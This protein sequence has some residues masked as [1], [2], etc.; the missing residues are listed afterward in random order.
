MKFAMRFT[1]LHRAISSLATLC[2]PASKA[3]PL[4]LLT[5][6]LVWMLTSCS[7]RNQPNV[8]LVTIDSLRADHLSCYG[9]E[10]LTTP[11]IDQL[12]DE[13]VRF[14]HALCDVTW[15]TPSMCSVMTGT[16]ATI[17]GFKSSNVNRLKDDAITLAEVLRNHQYATGAVVASFSL[18]HIYGLD[19]GF[20]YYDDKFTAPIVTRSDAPVQHVAARFHAS[21]KEQ[22]EFLAVKDVDESCRSEP[23]VTAAATTWLRQNAARRFFLWVHFFGPHGRADLR[24]SETENSQHHLDTYDADIAETDVEVGR[25]MQ[26]L[27]ELGLTKNTL[28]IL[29]ADHGESLGEHN[30]IG[31]GRDL[32]GPTLNV[33][34]IMRLPGRLPKGTSV[35]KLVRNIDIFPTVLDVLH[36]QFDHQ[37]SGESLLPVVLRNA[38]PNIRETYAETYFPAHNLAAA[39]V[40]LAD[41]STRKV[42]V[43]RRGVCTTRWSYIRTEPCPIFGFEDSARDVSAEILDSVK[44]EELY[45]LAEDPSEMHSIAAERPE[46]VTELRRHLDRYLDAE[47]QIPAAPRVKIDAGA[48]ERLRS[49]GYSG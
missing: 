38:G 24:R 2:R 34:L 31:H 21:G 17:H 5:A 40:T 13:G 22:G 35:H 18:D 30:T 39:T 49:L 43:V 33:P 32:Y 25:L 41:G 7:W 44:S 36:I 45:D 29:H 48:K 9:Y 14:E 16:Y 4:E 11:H 47:R 37:V 12:A 27:D 6:A 20:Q 8:L 28:V 15:T 3:I 19:Q 42:G 23:D 46:V 26:Q 1:M 10:K